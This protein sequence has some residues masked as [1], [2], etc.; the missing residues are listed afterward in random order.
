MVTY[1][2]EAQQTL[3]DDSGPM[4]RKTAE[5]QPAPRRL[6]NSGPNPTVHI[7]SSARGWGGELGQ[8]TGAWPSAACAW[9]TTLTFVTLSFLKHREQGTA[10]FPKLPGVLET[11][12]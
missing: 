6:K 9:P 7:R 3:V 8:I 2:C 12:G 1:D 10:C 11:E 5:Q 4:K